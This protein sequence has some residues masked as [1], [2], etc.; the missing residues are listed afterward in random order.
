MMGYKVKRWK[1]R[2]QKEKETVRQRGG[3]KGASERAEGMKTG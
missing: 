2:G 1:V 3:V